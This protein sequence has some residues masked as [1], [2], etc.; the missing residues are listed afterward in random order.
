M[1]TSRS[2]DEAI[3][4][5]S[6]RSNGLILREK[7]TACIVY[8]GRMIAGVERRQRGHA[9][10]YWQLTSC[11]YRKTSTKSI[12]SRLAKSEAR[13]RIDRIRSSR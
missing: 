4:P 10:G 13:P 5:L 7:S 6:K 9:R 8:G 2:L 3:C 11:V 12:H 1:Y